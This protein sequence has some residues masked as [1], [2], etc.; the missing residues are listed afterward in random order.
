MG[1]FGLYS[2]HRVHIRLEYLGRKSSFRSKTWRDEFHVV[3]TSPS[4]EYESFR[5]KLS[6]F[7]ECLAKHVVERE[8][9]RLHGE[10]S[11]L[12]GGVTHEM[13]E[14]EKGTTTNFQIMQSELP[15][16][17]ARRRSRAL[18][19]KLVPRSSLVHF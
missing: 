18:A 17:S 8:A 3:M 10:L 11:S 12:P 6:E 15:T 14:R 13:L 9:E 16:P 5:D 1:R 4:N 2:K 7:F 19:C